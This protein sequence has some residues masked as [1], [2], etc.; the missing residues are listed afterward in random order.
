[1]VGRD[2]V[3]QT[4]REC[5]PL[6]NRFTCEGI[7]FPGPPVDTASHA[8]DQPDEQES[9]VP[10]EVTHNS[11]VTPVP[12]H[13]NTPRSNIKPM[14]SGSNSQYAVIASTYILACLALALR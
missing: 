7:V 11:R 3:V 2:G 4:R 14:E 13:R 1:M 5:S 6:G 9:P 12:V 8:P 10:P